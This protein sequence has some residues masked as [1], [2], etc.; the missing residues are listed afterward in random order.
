M[1]TIRVE[2]T[3]GAMGARVT[4]I[5][6]STDLDAPTVTSLRAAWLEHLVLAFPSQHLTIEDLERLTLKF[7]PYGD[8]PFIAPITG[9]PHIIEV[10]RSADEKTSLFAGGWHSDWSFQEQPPSATILH[11]VDIPPVGGDTLFANMYDAYDNLPDATKAR[12]AGQS[13]IHSAALPYA[14]DGVY[15]ADDGPDR[16]MTIVA[17]DAA[18]ARRSHPIV[19]THPETGRKALFVNPGYVCGVEGLS[20]ED[21]FLLLIE[22][23]EHANAEAVVFRQAWEPDMVVMWDNRCTMH[24]ATGGYEG[25]DR[26]LRRATVRGEAVIAAA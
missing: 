23:F 3:G 10:R 17:S 12:V 24:M 19:R 2:P 4:G 16:S 1:P 21:A 22:L 11:G 7:G 5:D 8:D 20:D 6:L 18:T 13:A 15:G 26:L 9:H 14:K 25:H